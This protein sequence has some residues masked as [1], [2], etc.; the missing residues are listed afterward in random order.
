MNMKEE[1][2]GEEKS[3]NVMEQLFGESSYK[4]LSVDEIKKEKNNYLITGASGFI[5]SHLANMIKNKGHNVYGILRDVIPSDWLSTALSGCTIVQGDLRNPVML[6]RIIEHYDIDTVFHI[7]SHANVKQAMHIPY[8]VFETNVM[9]AVNVLEAVRNNPKF[10]IG[11]NGNVI[12]LNTDKSYGEKE[13]ADENTCYQHSEPY[14]T[15]KACQGFIAKSYRDTYDLNIKVAHSC[16]A[17]G[18]DPFN[19]RL[20]PNTIKDCIKGNSPIIYENDNSVREYIYIEDLIKALYI[21]TSENY[22]KNSYNIHTG[23][24]HNQKKI[25]ENIVRYY[26]DINFED[27][28]PV[29]KRVKLPFQI[30]RQSLISVNWNWT[31]S[32][33]FNE[34]LAETVDNFIIYKNDWM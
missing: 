15:S 29:K 21:L 8:E 24:I 9:G 4:K 10:K 23:W 28:K 1:K 32:W 20:I 26:N 6:K 18:Y 5:G 25:V 27:I 17:F 7:A 16:N 33:T 13:L 3:G 14:A 31:P 11:N 22:D 12:V 2:N 34:A 19:S 30:Q